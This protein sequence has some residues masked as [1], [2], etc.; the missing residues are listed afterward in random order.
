MVKSQTKPGPLSFIFHLYKEMQKKQCLRSRK[1]RQM[2]HGMGQE[3]EAGRAGAHHV[4][5]LTRGDTPGELRA[6]CHW[7]LAA[8]ACRMSCA[9]SGQH[10]CCVSK[11]LPSTSSRSFTGPGCCVAPVSDGVAQLFGVFSHFFI[12]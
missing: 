3:D 5:V 7:E 6:L 4:A 8:Q 2:W 12:F 1:A 10:F 11:I 9:R